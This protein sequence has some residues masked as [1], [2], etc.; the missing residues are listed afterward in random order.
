MVGPGDGQ[1]LD[2]HATTISLQLAGCVR[3]QAGPVRSVG[4]R[5]P[6]GVAHEIGLHR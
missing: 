1:V 3:A 4:D 5:N 2:L 6:R